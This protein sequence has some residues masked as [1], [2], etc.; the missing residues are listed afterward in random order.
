MPET[1]SHFDEKAGVA[2]CRTPWGRWY[3]TVGEVVVEVDLEKGTR[4]KECW[5][6]ILP[7]QL[8]CT[9]RQKELFNVSKL[10]YFIL[11]EDAA[12]IFYHV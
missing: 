8:T 7:N 3:Q 10:Y 6:T 1:N 2:V 5:V 4:A 12:K 9:V 11:K